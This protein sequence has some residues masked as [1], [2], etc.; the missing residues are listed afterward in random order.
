MC[1]LLRKHLCIPR[2]TAD[3]R[4]YIGQLI[5]GMKKLLESS[6]R[7]MHLLRQKTTK[8][9]QHCIKYLT[10]HVFIIDINTF[11][12]RFR[13]LIGKIVRVVIKANIEA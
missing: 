7:S 12:A 1:F 10:A 6:L 9:S 13:Q 3:G 4:R 2:P 5:M 11:W 8:V